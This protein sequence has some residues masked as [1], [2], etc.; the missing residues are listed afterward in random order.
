[1]KLLDVQQPF[2]LSQREKR[3]KECLD[4]MINVN[5]I[6]QSPAV[7]EIMETDSERV[8]TTQEEIDDKM[9]TDTSYSPDEDSDTLSTVISDGQEDNEQS[10]DIRSFGK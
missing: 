8:E 7:D 9:R 1:M 10:F 5:F 4:R 3:R 2:L 6:K